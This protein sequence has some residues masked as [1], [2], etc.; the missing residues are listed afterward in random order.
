MNK[1][2]SVITINY[3]DARRVIKFVKGI[4]KYGILDH[5]IIVDNNSTDNSFEMLS[6]IA[7]DKIKL[8][9]SGINKGYGYGNNY[10]IK[11]VNKNFDS[12]YI[13]IAN[14]DVD[15]K[16]K[17]VVDLCNILNRNQKAVM[18]STVMCDSDG[19][20]QNNTAWKVLTPLKYI[21]N[22][23]AIIRRLFKLDQYHKLFEYKDTDVKKVDC[24]AGSF[25]VLKNNNL[26]KKGLYDEKMFLYCEEDYL[27]L[28]LK[29]MGYN[30]L[31]L[32]TDNY[33]HAHGKT[34]G[35]IYSKTKQDRMIFKNKLYLL[36]KYLQASNLTLSF[37]QVFFLFCLIERMVGRKFKQLSLRRKM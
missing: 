16:E 36:K 13:V 9:S 20:K 21:L 2:I 26:V 25:F 35:Q 8:I 5:I 22:E 6:K 15:F 4:S 34:I 29:K 27:G 1:D 24:L 11:Y 3:N 37:A 18:A 33:I 23:G 10:G 31:L 30:A 14:P 17:T 12:D 19:D 32:L 7:N 28:K